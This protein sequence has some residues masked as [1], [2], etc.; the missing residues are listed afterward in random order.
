[1]KT[2]QERSNEWIVDNDTGTSSKTIWA[3]MNGIEIKVNTLGGRYD[4]PYDPGDFGRCYRLF[5]RIPEWRP[6]LQEVA[7]QFPAWQPLV[8]VWEKLEGLHCAKRYSEV[9]DLIQ[10][11]EDEIYRLDGWVKTGLYSYHRNTSVMETHRDARVKV[12]DGL[13]SITLTEN[14]QP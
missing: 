9:Y 12:E 3:V 14:P 1:M 6:R 8:D 4:R 13:I 5:E 10:S 11:V 2:V 7:K